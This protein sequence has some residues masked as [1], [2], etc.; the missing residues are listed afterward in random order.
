MLAGTEPGGDARALQELLA[1]NAIESNGV[2]ILSA[3]IA[4]FTTHKVIDT[5]SQVSGLAY[6]PDGTQ[7]PQ[8]NSTERCCSGIPPAKAGRHSGARKHQADG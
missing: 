3:Q 8:H 1:A 7:S 5:F 4:R 2:P 6:S